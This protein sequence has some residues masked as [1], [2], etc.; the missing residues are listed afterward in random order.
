[1]KSFGKARDKRLPAHPTVKPA[2][3]DCLECCCIIVDSFAWER[4]DPG[5][6]APG[7]ASRLC[8]TASSR[9]HSPMSL[10]SN[11]SVGRSQFRRTA[12]W[13]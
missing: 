2:I 13:C 9:D 10:Q 6:R 11:K 3:L 7:G 5:R 1:M 8:T 12:T 4:H